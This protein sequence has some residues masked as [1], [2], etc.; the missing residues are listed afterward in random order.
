MRIRTRMV[1]LSFVGAMS[2]C[3]RVPVPVA[4][5]ATAPSTGRVAFVVPDTAAIPG[6]PEGRSIRR[7]L[8]LVTATPDS[9]PETQRSALRC[10]SCH[11]D[12]GTRAGV[13]PWV[14]VAA[15]FPQYRS[16]SGTMVSLEERIRG[17]FARSLNA[18]PPAHG[19]A[20][21]VDVASYLTWL[22]QGTPIGRETE[23]QGFPRLDVLVPDTAAGRGVFVAECA[24]CHGAEGQGAPSS[25]PGIPAAPPLWG[26]RSYNIGAGMARLTMAAGFIRVAMPYDRPGSLTPQ[27][28]F[29]VAAY[30][31]ARPRPDF[32]G[33]ERDWPNGDAPPD[34][35]YKTRQQALDP[36]E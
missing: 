23:G 6:G 34:A 30:M 7:G 31:N 35:A 12:A 15:R 2:A 21:L 4:R 25:V 18:T 9:F 36:P 28:A 14:G 11:L 26:P 16:R 3:E 8:A 32:P 17:C 33:K 10:A 27:Q 22:S 1:M 13:M 5:S 29:D 20:D 24:R 19:S